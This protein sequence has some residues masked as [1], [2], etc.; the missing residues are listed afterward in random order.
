MEIRSAET[1]GEDTLSGPGV[2]GENTCL[3]GESCE[4]VASTI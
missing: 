1:R 2:R 3:L 4:Y